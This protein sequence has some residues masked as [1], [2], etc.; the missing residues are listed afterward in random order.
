ML[1]D[2]WRFTYVN[3]EAEHILRI[4]RADLLGKVIW[5]VFP[6]FIGSKTYRL[7][8]HAARTRS[9][10]TFEDYNP[11]FERCYAH[12]VYPTPDGQLA[13]YFEDI[14]EQRQAE[15]ALLGSRLQLQAELNDTKLLQ[16]LSGE[17]VS[18]E[19][20]SALYGK[21]LDA[22]MQIMRSEFASMQMLYPDRGARGELRLLAFRGFSQ[23]AAEHWE[24]VSVDSGCTCGIA[25]QT[26]QR[27]L[28]ADLETSREILGARDLE[29]Y[30]QLGI[31][32]VQSTPLL[33]RNGQLV[34][35]IST[36]WRQI[37]VPSDRDFR[38][39]DILA[40]Q[41][42]DLIERVTS[43]EQALARER[44]ARTEAER[45]AR[46]K[47]DFLATVSHELRTPLNAI[48]GWSHILKKDLA[49][50]E[51]A[52]AA[53]EVIERN[54]RIQAQLIEDLL[55]MSRILSGK[56]RLNIEPV[57]LTHIIGS[58][59]DSLSPAAEAKGIRIKR[60][61]EPNVGETTG[62]PARL[63]QVVWNLLSNAVKFT[64]TGGAI[65]IILERVDTHIEI[66]ITDTGDGIS[67]EFL[68]HIFDRF[69]QAD[70]SAS[71][72]HGGLGIGLALVRQLAELHGGRVSASSDGEGHGSTFVVK[73]PL[74]TTRDGGEHLPI[75]DESEATTSPGYLRTLLRNIHVLAVD[76]EIDALT[77]VRRVLE[78]NEAT[79]TAASSSREALEILS[80]QTFDVIVSDIGMP[81]M[82][83]Y[84]FMTEIRN[85]ENHTPAIALTAYARREDRAKSIASGYQA[86]ISKPAEIGE[87][88][89]AVAS[90]AHRPT[91]SSK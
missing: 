21:I 55:D 47:D 52:K 75:L 73:L 43:R 79:V 6:E 30:A 15:E 33:S 88:L 80:T 27:V 56:M 25:F 9:A 31:R 71:R 16:R 37:H 65:E 60:T 86:H 1:D 61:L 59:V 83:G 8:E 74:V 42:A 85:R 62:D 54:G 19:D 46:L 24:W 76:D 3:A 32:A 20:V 12:K 36:H 82:D 5:E 38:L 70:A 10:V 50:P 66:R 29:N 34:G 14:T 63:Q 72:T 17:L 40:R 69:R 91:A 84:T 35:M 11:V 67:P 45:A 2:G 90:L 28:M 81:G 89:D 77:F 7:L 51:R 22:A 68:P 49:S 18:E 44:T 26:H 41:A 23:E 78:E 13:V 48:L 87:L 57:D 4:T 39:L 64:P 53:A 58:A